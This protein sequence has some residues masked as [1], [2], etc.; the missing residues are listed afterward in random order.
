MDDAHNSHTTKKG[1][2]SI[3]LTKM[4]DDSRGGL[5]T[6]DVVEAGGVER[7]KKSACLPEEEEERLTRYGFLGLLFWCAL[8]CAAYILLFTVSA[9]L[10]LSLFSH[11]RS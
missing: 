10:E 9:G 11:G 1:A 4:K 8:P 5:K 6:S 3:E 2:R 7:N